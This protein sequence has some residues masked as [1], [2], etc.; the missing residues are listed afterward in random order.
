M[1][2][3]EG[4]NTSYGVAII[5]LDP[6]CR[7][8]IDKTLPPE[9]IWDVALDLEKM[10]ESPLDPVPSI[11]IFGRP[12]EGVS[13]N[14]VAQVARMQH[15]TQPIYF[16]TSVRAGFD[17]KAFRKN[18]FSEAF[19]LP[20]D[21]DAFVRQLKDDLAQIT[22]GGFRS[23]R[24]VQLIDLLPNEELNFDTYVYMPVNKKHIRITA[25]GDSIDELQ[26]K[27][28]TKAQINSVQVTSDQMANF[29]EFT[30]K[31]LRQLQSGSGL[32]ETERK[33]RMTSAIR[34]LV[35]SVFSDS[36]AASTLE[37]GRSIV[38]NCQSIVKNFVVSGGEKNEWYEKMLRVT[39]A[40]GGSYSHAGNVATFGAL[41]S[42]AVGVGKPEDVALAGLLHDLG[43][44]DVPA[45][46]QKKSESERT[47]EEE[48]I[49][50]KH[51]ESVDALI[52]ARKMILPD[53]VTRA[54][55]Q[56]HERWSGTGYP[57]GLAA[58]RI[59]KEAQ[60]LS[61]SDRFDEMTMTQEGKPRMSPAAAFKEIYAE[62]T[63]DPSNAQFDT[64]LLKKFLVL[65]P[66]E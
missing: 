14:E 65:F 7:S 51:V 54:I 64:E 33:E 47:P 36:T 12:P 34:G 21:D 15:P 66:S 55:A 8:A 10:S 41:F 2:K 6:I 26:L 40:E 38:G 24:A 30:G 22:K 31:K 32:S 27:R 35:S 62:N 9:R 63:R 18:G 5:G 28:L 58:E 4:S 48:A 59:T 11:L 56:H 52:K 39:G 43:L 20:I 13:L 16:A 50:R 49:Y 45:E 60:V 29:Y 19:L 17:V 46:I 53:T 1:S 3:G 57:R 44:A 61:L 25:S 42:L 23:Y 37:A